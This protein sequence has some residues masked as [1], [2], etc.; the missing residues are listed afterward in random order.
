MAKKELTAEQKTAMEAAQ[1]QKREDDLNTL[2]SLMEYS[3][4]KLLKGPENPFGTAGL[5]AGNMK[6]GAFLM[7]P[8]AD[9]KRKEFYNEKLQEAARLNTIAQ[10]E[11][12]TNYELERNSTLA[13][14]GASIASKFGDL[15]KLMN[16]K[17]KGSKLKVP[18]QFKNISYEMILAKMQSAGED[19][20]P[21]EV[22]E[23]AIKLYNAL[24]QVGTSG[25][26]WE[27][28]NASYMNGVN[29]FSEE[30]N[31]KYTPKAAEKKA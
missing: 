24:M 27:M 26:A 1:K 13:F 20:Q 2:K 28:V 6:Y 15:E 4:I 30:I 3:A 11:Y 19:Y 18:E 8:Y 12:T 5:N 9:T 16:E 31:K 7:S 17:N 22:E 10:P 25:V 21:S 23:D 14:E 29:Q